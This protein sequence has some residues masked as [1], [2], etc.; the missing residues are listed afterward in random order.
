MFKKNTKTT[1]NLS[2]LSAL[3]SR[4]PEPLLSSADVALA[5]PEILSNLKVVMMA[6]REIQ[7]N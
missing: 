7:R 1:K 4:I 3:S 6:T 5:T 2:S